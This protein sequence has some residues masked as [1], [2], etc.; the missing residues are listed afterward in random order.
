M[1]PLLLILI[2][3]SPSCKIGMAKQPRRNMNKPKPNELYGRVGTLTTTNWRNTLGMDVGDYRV[4]SWRC[5]WGRTWDQWPGPSGQTIT[6][7]KLLFQEIPG[8][9]TAAI[10][11]Q[12][13]NNE[14][15]SSLAFHWI[16]ERKVVYIPKKPDP[17]TPSDYCSLSMLEILY[18][19][20]AR[21]LYNKQS[22]STDIYTPL[23]RS[24]EHSEIAHGTPPN[25]NF[26]RFK[27]SSD[28]SPK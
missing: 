11:Q 14:L 4:W 9:F 5:H 23:W 24:W 19:I 6:I 28:R 22:V 26:A 12:V 13:F 20:P 21:I 3:S 7:F 8:I 27:A 17:N 16:K 1:V 2:Q 18:K 25:R 15:A 10:N